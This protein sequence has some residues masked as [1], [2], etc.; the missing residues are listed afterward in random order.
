MA[1]LAYLLRRARLRAQL[2]P[3]AVVAG[4]AVIAVLCSALAFI[5]ILGGAG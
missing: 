3:G 4:L 2:N 1:R 5:L